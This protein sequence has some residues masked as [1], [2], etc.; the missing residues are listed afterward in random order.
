MLVKGNRSLNESKQTN[1]PTPKTKENRNQSSL[2]SPGVFLQMLLF[3]I[4]A[5][6]SPLS[7]VSS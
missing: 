7:S 6:S 5:L 4:T 2:Y 3:L 1:K